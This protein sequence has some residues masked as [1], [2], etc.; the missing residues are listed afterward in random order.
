[1]TFSPVGESYRISIHMIEPVL[2]TGIALRDVATV[3]MPGLADDQDGL[4]WS[5]N[6]F[7]ILIET[8][9]VSLPFDI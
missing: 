4:D 2:E 6:R 7:T 8:S 5:F 1:M 3:L 9:P